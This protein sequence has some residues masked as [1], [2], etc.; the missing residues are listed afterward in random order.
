MKETLQQ[1]RFA[2]RE[3]CQGS[4]HITLLSALIAPIFIY[5]IIMWLGNSDL[6]WSLVRF[7]D[8]SE[9]DTD[10]D[11]LHYLE[12]IMLDEITIIVPIISTVILLIPTHV[13]FKNNPQLRLLPIKNWVKIAAYVFIV[14]ILTAIAISVVILLDYAIPLH[15]HRLYY[16]EAIALQE[17]MGDLYKRVD[18]RSVIFWPNNEA[19]F[20]GRKFSGIISL[21]IFFNLLVWILF[22]LFQKYSLVKSIIG[23]FLLLGISFNVRSYIDASFRTISVSYNYPMAGYNSFYYVYV[24]LLII[25][26]LITIYYQLKEREV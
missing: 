25:L 12:G 9:F 15:V 17:S 6:F 8:K 1:I 14:L 13:R 20:I 11:Y 10:A 21:S 4:N 18:S 19:L 23:I 24:P 26:F 7:P 2:T 3:L 22:N 5:F 16:E